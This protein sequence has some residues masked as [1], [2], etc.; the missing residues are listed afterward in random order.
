MAKAQ[1]QMRAMMSQFQAAAG[2]G[3]GHG[4]SHGGGKEC[5][6]SHGDSS[7]MMGPS[8]QQIMAAQQAMFAGYQDATYEVHISDDSQ[9]YFDEA[10]NSN[11]IL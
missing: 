8:M 9:A 10:I 4:H 1:A 5:G 11:Q 2:G 6:H 3:G 7:A